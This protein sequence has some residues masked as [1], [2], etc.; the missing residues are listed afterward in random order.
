MLD[1]RARLT[2]LI[3][4]AEV[5]ECLPL[6]NKTCELHCSTQTSIVETSY[7]LIVK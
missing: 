6:L 1:N 3:K 4:D 5:G 7:K 2:Y